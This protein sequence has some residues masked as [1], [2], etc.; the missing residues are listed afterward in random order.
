MKKTMLLAAVSR[1]LKLGTHVILLLRESLLR[2]YF[3]PTRPI[4]PV[5]RPDIP[6]VLICSVLLFMIGSVSLTLATDEAQAQ[7]KTPA[8]QPI[9]TDLT[10]A[11]INGQP[12]KASE[13]D[14]YAA[15]AQLPRE[16]ALEDLI[17]LRLVRAAASARQVSAPV[18]PWS[19]EERAGVEYALAKALGLD[20][21]PPRISLVV[22]HAWVKDAEDEKGRS[23]DRAL[24]ER[25]RALVGAGATIPDAYNQLQADGA[26]WHIGDHEEYLYE[27]IPAEAHDLPEGSLSPIIPGD[28][29]LH[30]FKIYQRKQELPPSS[31]I[32][33]LLSGRLR[34]DATIEIPE[35]PPPANGKMQPD[36]VPQ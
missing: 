2:N 32:R 34:Q 20:V 4:R 17:D 31:E 6:V 11:L 26:A 15:T 22:D 28:G 18:R 7:S 36:V 13:L 35:T 12:I 24:L 30:L 9:A 19:A 16:E 3:W 29:G 27:I 5:P 33:G 25:L 23:S 14:A 1:C 8:A 10:A 21:P